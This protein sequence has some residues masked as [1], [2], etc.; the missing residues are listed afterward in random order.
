MHNKTV[1]Q[2]PKGAM[3]TMAHTQ[4]PGEVYILKSGEIQIE[5]IFRFNSKNLNRYLPGD[6]FGYVSAITRNPHS[7]TLVAATDCIVIRLSLENFF[8][9]LR[10]N[11][12][13][14]LKIISYN[15]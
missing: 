1:I 2:Y 15:A 9:Y 3:I 11:K 6:T 7:S 14:F 12:D 4:N 13:V 8:E 10:N 5:S